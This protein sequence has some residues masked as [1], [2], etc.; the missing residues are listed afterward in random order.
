MNILIDSSVW[1]D[2]FRSG[3]NSNN[4]DTLIDQNV[5]CINSL[6]LAEIIPSLK[7]RNQNSLIDLLYQIVNIKL[8]I[9]WDKIINYQTICLANGINKVGIPDL[10]I[11]DNVI[12]NKLTLYSLDNHFK[13]ISKH[14]EFDLFDD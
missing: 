7:H 3:I 2:Y 6:I 1:I 11:L 10:V 5:I 14:I 13:L 4:L 8:N 12:H 9:N